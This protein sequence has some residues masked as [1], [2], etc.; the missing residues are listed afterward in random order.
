MTSQPAPSE[1]RIPVVALDPYG[2]GTGH[3]GEAAGL[4][5]LGPVSI[6]CRTS[7]TPRPCE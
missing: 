2:T 1:K 5:G 7:R 3:R 4:R 6:R